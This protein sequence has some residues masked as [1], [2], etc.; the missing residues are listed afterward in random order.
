MLLGTN[1]GYTQGSPVPGCLLD[2]L[3]PAPWYY[4]LLQL[5]ALGLFCLMTLPF[6]RRRA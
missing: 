6:R 2:Y 1:Y 5:P 3:G 4:L